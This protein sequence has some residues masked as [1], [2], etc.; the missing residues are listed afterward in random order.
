MK[1]LAETINNTWDLNHQGIKMLDQ[2]KYADALKLFKKGLSI[3][4]NDAYIINNKGCALHNMGKLAQAIK[5]YDNALS[6]KS[7]DEDF[8]NNKI[9][10]IK[11]LGKQK[12]ELGMHKRAIMYYDRAISLGAQDSEIYVYKSISLI[13]QERFSMA[14]ESITHALQLDPNS[15]FAKITE[16]MLK[17]KLDS[18]KKHTRKTSGKMKSLTLNLVFTIKK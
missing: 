3:N 6:I 4:P 8:F 12:T 1:K 10:A 14:L 13:K 15:E 17:Q 9:L 5:C 11:E 16:K 7:D 18:S 2:K